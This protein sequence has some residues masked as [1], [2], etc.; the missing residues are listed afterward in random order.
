MKLAAFFLAGILA[1]PYSGEAKTIYIPQDYPT[2]QAGINAALHGDALIV[3]P[4]TYVENIDFHGKAITVKS[5]GG[6]TVTHIDGNR[7]GSVVA[8]K[9][10]E[11]LQSVLS[12]FTVTNGSGTV[13]T[14]GIYKFIYG[15]GIYCDGS[16]PAISGNHIFDNKIEILCR[17]GLLHP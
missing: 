13:V 2:I 7:S 3:A 8:F 16:S 15:A 10:G 9:S 11:N 14:A 17:S 5:S 6:A 12:G 1:V 4:G